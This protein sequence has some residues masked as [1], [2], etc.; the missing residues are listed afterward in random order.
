[1]DKGDFAVP[2]AEDGV[3]LEF[4]AGDPCRPVWSGRWWGK[5]QAVSEVPKLA[6]G[7]RDASQQPP[8]GT[9]M[10]TLA[11]GRS[12]SEPPISYAAQYPLNKVFKTKQGIVVELDDTPGAVRLHFWH[13]AQTWREVHPD[14]SLVERVAQ[15][16]Y[17]CIEVDDRL[18]VKG[19]WDI[20]VEGNCTLRVDGNWT[21][22]VGGD[23]IEK[24]EGDFRQEIG[25]DFDQT[26]DG[27]IMRQSAMGITDQSGNNQHM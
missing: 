24:I 26:V 6:R 10:M 11:D 12:A 27:Q 2:D 23:K 16:R 7:T 5:P 19:D 17:T 4:E 9:D 13:P 3:W 20:H 18:H 21:V 22:R 8:K 14:G 25:G 15:E 1:M